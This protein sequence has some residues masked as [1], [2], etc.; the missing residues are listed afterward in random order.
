MPYTNQMHFFHW[1]IIKFE[2][3]KTNFMF[4]WRFRTK[5]L[6]IGSFWTTL[7]LFHSADIRWIYC[8]SIM[9]LIYCIVVYE[10]WNEI[11]FLQKEY[12]HFQ[13]AF[14]IYLFFKR[15]DWSSLIFPEIWSENQTERVSNKKLEPSSRID[16]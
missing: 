8:R 1:S 2:I 15:L 13:L 3:S 4:I 12:K 10:V 14:F 9:S 5:C 7:D 6:F 16:H 11:F